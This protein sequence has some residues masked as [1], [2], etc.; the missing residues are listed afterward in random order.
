MKN[1]Q[2]KV[3]MLCMLLILCLTVKTN[4]QAPTIT[5]T[6]GY[7]IG[8]NI[9]CVGMAYGASKYVAAATNGNIYTS[10]DGTTWTKSAS[11][12]QT[13]FN[14]SFG[15]SLFL[16]VGT[17]G[18]LATSTDAITWTQRTTGTTNSLND[19]QYLQSAYYAVGQN[20]TI[21]SSSNGTT[22]SAVTVNVGTATDFFYQIAYGGGKYIISAGST[23]GQGPM[24]YQSTTAVS[25]SWS[26]V[27]GFGV[28]GNTSI[29]KMVFLNGKFIL[30]TSSTSIFTS[31]DGASWTNITATMSVTLPNSTTT[32]VG[33]GN[34][35]NTIYYDGTTYYW[36]GYSNYNSGGYGA[37]YTSTNLTA[38]TLQSN[39][40]SILA[41]K[42]YALNGKHFLAGNEGFAISTNG[43]SY[44]FPCGSFNGLAFNGTTYVGVGAPSGGSG[45]IF[46]STTFNSNTWTNRSTA[47]LKPLFGVVYD[48]SK[49]VA[50]GDRT[51]VSS[52]DGATWSTIA[53]PSEIFN[54]MAY[55]NT[56][57]V[58]C[59]N[60]TEYTSNFIKYSTDGTTWITANSSNYT[61][62][63]V[64]YVNNTFFAMGIDNNYPA[65]SGI[66]MRS[67]DGITWTNVT[68]TGLAFNVYLFSDVTWDGTKYHFTGADAAANAF[69]SISTATPT[70]TSSYA[71]KG[72]I[73]NMPGGVTLGFTW[74]EGCVS[75]SGGKYVGSAIDVSSYLAYIIYS[76][77]GI[78]WT[79][80]ATNDKSVVSDI[81]VDNGKF[82]MVGTGDEKITVEF[83]TS[84]T[85]DGSTW[86]NGA[87]SASIDA[88]IA[89]TTVPSASFTC[90]T[91]TINSGVALTTTGIT[92]TVNGNITNNGNGIA[93]TGGLTIA[94]TAALAGTAFSFNG[95]LTVNSGV[96]LNTNSKLTLSSNASATARIAAG[97]S[98]GGY[99]SGTV[100]VQ[101]Y[102]QGTY[103]KFRFLGH[104]FTSLPLTELTDNIDITGTITGS[105]ANGFTSTTSN[106]PSAYTFNEA[107]GDA[108]TNDAGWTAI[109]SGNALTTIAQGQGIR[110]LIRGTKGQA[111]SLNGGA[112][113]PA[114]VTLGMSGTLKQGDFTQN[115]NYTSAAKGWNLIS[116]PYFSNIDWTTVT[117]TNVNNAVYVYKPSGS[118]YASW[119]NGSSTNGGSNVIEVG[120]AFFV[121][122]NAGSPSLGWHETDK[123]ATSQP[124][125]MFR[126]TNNITNR[127]SL[128]LENETT[129]SKDEVIVRFGDDPAT[130]GFDAKYDAQNMIASTH[131]LYVLDQQ[132]NQ[133]SVYH[134]TALDS[135]QLENRTISLGFTASSIGSHNIK[136]KVLNALTDGNKAFLKDI[137]SN[138]LTEL[139]DNTSYSFEVTSE[140]ASQG[141]A[142]FS[143]V[144]NPKEKVAPTIKEFSIKLSP[145]PAKGLV[146]LVYAQTEILNTTVSIANAAGKQVKSINLGKVQYGIE[147]IDISKLSAGFY[148]VQYSNGVETRTEKLIVE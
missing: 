64:R 81:I 60:T 27:G 70:T 23:V 148:F 26:T 13:L 59:G 128:T 127:L 63:K 126:T 48:G 123:V 117:K 40:L 135:W 19:V 33:N 132:Q 79:S 25:N 80:V 68:P 11:L 71:N 139:T 44:S 39:P 118:V 147:K 107:N 124:I 89:S 101:R 95:T 34:Y 103:R 92:A 49:F 5:K 35:F 85:W 97:S 98:A 125:T 56:K 136:V 43:I 69:F 114:A 83:V 113:T 51:V 119:I 122:A 108:N 46:S 143:I 9:S 8:A 62:F 38:L 31:S 84:T 32:T 77:D 109:T 94:T 106:A 65:S 4:A 78:S 99:I 90:K 141:G 21:I 111:N 10:S 6:I 120:N 76:S 53:T 133:Y 134:G 91:L 12:S 96:V 137:Y 87:P 72:T 66:I 2:F 16:A 73:T 115:L 129:Q 102:V 30:I 112:Y 15:N 146:Q 116:N 18:Y 130:N 28:F 82:R 36:C 104:P 47:T 3:A 93:G 75:Y 86:S 14:I 144:F 20:R 54:T 22:W 45:N 110:V 145:N 58:I 57:Y 138:T 7:P 52:T 41:N 74:N 24:T 88:I 67:T 55:G 105:N 140:A 29:N 100:A 37:I 50:V 131:D 61:F 1:V 17:N 42:A 121:R 142:R